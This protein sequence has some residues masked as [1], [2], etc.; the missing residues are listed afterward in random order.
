MV[1]CAGDGFVITCGNRGVK[2]TKRVD[3]LDDSHSLDNLLFFPAQY[4]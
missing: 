2:L 1:A 3:G 4:R